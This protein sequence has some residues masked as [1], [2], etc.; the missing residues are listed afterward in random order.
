MSGRNSKL[1][2]SKLGRQQVSIVDKYRTFQRE[3]RSKEGTRL[4]NVKSAREDISDDEIIVKEKRIANSQKRIGAKPSRGKDSGNKKDLGSQGQKH[5]L[6]R[7]RRTNGK[8]AYRSKYVTNKSTKADGESQVTFENIS[9][10]LPIFKGTL[11]EKDNF[12]IIYEVLLL[13]M[14]KMDDYSHRSSDGRLSDALKAET[15]KYQELFDKYRMLVKSAKHY[16]RR[17]EEA[18][19]EV[20][21]IRK[22]YDDLVKEYDNLGHDYDSLRGEAEALEIENNEL[23]SQ[24][25]HIS[26][27]EES[28]EEP[29][30]SKRASRSSHSDESSSLNIDG[31]IQPLE[32]VGGESSDSSLQLKE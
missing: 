27:A 18:E 25:D 17:M 6:G 11:G 5:V 4:E 1:F 21:E 19:Y 9:T 26:S 20:C 12:H 31:L 8:T 24:F 7:P 3:G 16:K 14:E 32:V 10:L 30:N 29:L 13:M 2:G 22:K 23:R 28:S 15:M